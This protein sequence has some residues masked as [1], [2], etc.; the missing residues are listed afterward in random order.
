MTKPTPGIPPPPAWSAGALLA[1]L[2]GALLRQSACAA[3]GKHH[4][5]RTAMSNERAD[6][7]VCSWT[8]DEVEDYLAAQAGA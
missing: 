1:A 5:S 3:I 7:W 6:R 4:G 2:L 8:L